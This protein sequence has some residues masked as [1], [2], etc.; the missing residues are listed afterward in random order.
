MAAITAIK[1]MNFK[2]LKSMDSRPAHRKAPGDS[3]YLNTSQLTGAVIERT[4]TTANPRPIAVSM[5]LDTATKE[6]IP[7]K[8]GEEDIADEYRIK[9]KSDQ[10]FHSLFSRPPSARTYNFENRFLPPEHR[11]IFIYF[12][13]GSFAARPKAR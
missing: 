8:I 11:P 1:V 9:K 4:K 2:K 5:F 10:V 3:R 6:H 7:K 12:S 13:S